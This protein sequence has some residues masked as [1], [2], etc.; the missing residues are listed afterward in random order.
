[1]P[2][3]MIKILNDTLTNDI[4]SFEQPGLGFYFFIFLFTTFIVHKMSFGQRR[5]QSTRHKWVKLLYYGDT[6]MSHQI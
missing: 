5:K 3:L 2:Y 1:M 4:V 6:L